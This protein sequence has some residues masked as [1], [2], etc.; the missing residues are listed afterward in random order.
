M[1]ASD[2][3]L[4]GERAAN[5]RLRKTPRVSVPS[6]ASL[7]RFSSTPGNSWEKRAVHERVSSG[8][9][10]FYGRTAWP[11]TGVSDHWLATWMGGPWKKPAA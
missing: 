7:S 6:A 2:W 8:E 4:Q 5:K 10:G 1:D 9:I 11:L 3:V